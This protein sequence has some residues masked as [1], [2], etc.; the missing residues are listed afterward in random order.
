MEQKTRGRPRKNEVVRDKK[1]T[2]RLSKEELE[3]LEYMS[4]MDKTP[5]QSVVGRALRAYF[6][7]RK[8]HY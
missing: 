6:A 5:K 8:D 2:V 3:Y 1:V 4:K 7:L